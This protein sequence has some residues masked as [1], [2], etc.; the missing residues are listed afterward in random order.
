MRDRLI[1]TTGHEDTS[2]AKLEEIGDHIKA[3]IDAVIR[4]DGELTEARKENDDL[5]ERI[6]DL[7]SQLEEAFEA[8]KEQGEPEP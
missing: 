7:E 6:R 5:N 3:V 2:I 8:L 1:N 4:L